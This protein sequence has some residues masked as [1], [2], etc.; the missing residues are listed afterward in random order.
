MIYT[1][2][3]TSIRS[4]SQSVN[5]PSYHTVYSFLARLAQKGVINLNDE[6]LPLSKDY[7][8]NKLDELSK[9]ITDLTP[10]EREELSFYLKEYTLWW[11]SDPKSGFEGV[12]KSF[13][14]S[15][16]GDRFRPFAYQDKDFTLNI[17][18]ILGIQT[19]S[20]DGY[21]LLKNSKGFWT[22]GLLGK[23]IGYSL[24][25]RASSEEG[26]LGDYLRTFS[27]E[28][29]VIGTKPNFRTF[30]YNEVNFQ[31]VG[32]WS[33]GKISI[34]K[35]YMPIGYGQGGKIILSE[36]AP[37]F[38]LIRLDITPKDW[39]SFNYAHVWLNSNIIDSSSIHPTLDP[40]RNE[41]Q[42]RDKFLATHSITLRTKRG[43][44][45][46]VGES[47]IYSDKLKIAYLIPI[48]LFSAMSHYMGEL[49]NNSISNSSIYAQISSR[50]LLRK[51]H[52]YA[53][54]F[55]D[56]L[57]L[58]Q[59]QDDTVSSRNH[60]AYQFGLSIADFP[61]RNLELRIEY[62][63]IQPFAYIHFIPVQSYQ[64]NG[65][66]LGHWIGSNA[67]QFYSSLEYRIK[68]GLSFKALYYFIR[69]GSVGSGA[70]QVFDDRNKFPFLWGEVTNYT[71]LQMSLQYELIHDLFIRFGYNHSDIFN[72]KTNNSNLSDSVYF[73]LNFGF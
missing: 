43:F 68:R 37:S 52:I 59:V 13:L 20:V 21:S 22:Y 38:P 66:N 14:Q 60:T 48:S 1:I 64:N 56:E 32:N 47:A 31:I 39:F 35:N 50:N 54:F 69:K 46:M 49:V 65:Y 51:T 10:L 29:G 45:L 3:S 67:D 28:T 71:K 36:K 53:N 72:T 30:N 70:Q 73:G 34:G 61:I 11:R 42:F 26:R 19:E 24:D 5:E 17:Q 25:F 27:Y 63:K 62:S 23:H 4:Y 7:I 9:K 57:R 18:P 44:S 41:Y 55:I 12:Y 58:K 2:I 8:Y 6:I 15:G 33:W 16:I 40:S